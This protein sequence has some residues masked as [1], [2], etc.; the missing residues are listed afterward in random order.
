MI[1]TRTHDACHEIFEHMV[2][3]SNIFWTKFHG[4]L[5]YFFS[6]NIDI[7][8][9]MC[10]QTDAPPTVLNTCNGFYC[11][12]WLVDHFKYFMMQ[13]HVKMKFNIQSLR[14]RGIICGFLNTRHVHVLFIDKNR[15]FPNQVA[16]WT[17]NWYG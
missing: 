12:N 15:A 8:W 11:D 3:F 1:C 4:V 5:L 14:Y 13:I 7:P 16:G 10:I 2:L 9:V 6:S 17:E